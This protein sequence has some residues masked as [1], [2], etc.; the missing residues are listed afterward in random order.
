M[1]VVNNHLTRDKLRQSTH[2]KPPNLSA[3]PPCL[4]RNPYTQKGYSKQEIKRKALSDELFFSSA[5]KMQFQVQ[6]LLVKAEVNG[7]KGYKLPKF[8]AFNLKLNTGDSIA[9]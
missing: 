3:A 1:L 2:K 9:I 5:P 8:E 6:K 4:V 7:K